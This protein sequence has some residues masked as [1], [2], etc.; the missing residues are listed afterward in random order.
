MGNSTALPIKLLLIVW[1]LAIAVLDELKR[2]ANA[3]DISFSTMT[4]HT[5][6]ERETEKVINYLKLPEVYKW[7]EKKSE[8][9]KS[10]SIGKNSDGWLSQTPTPGRAKGASEGGNPEQ[11]LQ[12]ALTIAD[13]I[14]DPYDRATI[15]NDIALQYANLGKKEQGIAILSQSLEAAKKIADTSVKVT[16]MLGIA[17]NYFELEQITTANEILSESIELANSVEDKSLKSRLLTKIALK[18]AEIGQDEQTAILLSQSQELIEQ[19]T[20]PVTTFPFQPAPMEGSFS[21]GGALESFATTTYTVFANTNLY[22][23]WAVDDIDLEADLFLSF[24][25]GRTINNYRPGGIL[26][27]FYRHHFNP[28][29][30]FFTDILITGNLNIFAAA[31]DDEDLDYV[32]GIATGIGLNLWRKEQRQ[33]V[34]LQLGVGARYEYADIDFQL[35]RN[36]TEPTLNLNLWAKGFQLWTAKVDRLF[37]VTLLF[38]DFEDFFLLSRTKFSFPLGEKWSFDNTLW[39]RYRNQKLLE[40]NPN[41]QVFFTT[42]IGFKF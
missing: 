23:Q 5:P 11:L 9:G 15:L 42:G 40:T 19:A 7:E 38:D 6:R 30:N 2:D 35:L 10:G 20:E 34:D 36:G 37:G 39:L 17:Q 26:L 4:A 1:L 18:H 25:S 14:K 28:Q 12:Q 3:K 13:T 31:T 27:S 21:F 24:D 33:F 22:K 41:L 8:L 29:W 32:V 16:V